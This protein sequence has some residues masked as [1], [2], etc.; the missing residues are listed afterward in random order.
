[1][2]KAKARVR[3][4][5]LRS[6]MLSLQRILHCWE[7]KYSRCGHVM[8]RFA[9]AI[10]RLAFDLESPYELPANH[11]LE[12]SGLKGARP[13]CDYAG[14]G[15]AR[16]LLQSVSLPVQPFTNSDVSFHERV[17]WCAIPFLCARTQW[18][19][20]SSG[21]CQRA[22]IHFTYYH[23]LGRRQLPL[24]CTVTLFEFG[25]LSLAAN[26]LTSPMT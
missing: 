19:Q 7:M 10:H 17:H 16:A 11:T 1:M 2:S 22:G 15:V 12:F 6:R 8:P 18:N 24:R 4:G 3:G 5:A 23:V 20:T 13:T 25:V 9:R 14:M 21:E 26:D